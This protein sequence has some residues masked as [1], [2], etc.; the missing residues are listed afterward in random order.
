MMP[1][2]TRKSKPSAGYTLVGT[3]SLP[4]NQVTATG[5]AK[6]DGGESRYR[7]LAVCAHPVQYSSPYFRRLAQHP[8]I[9]LLVAYCSLKG[10]EPT[11]DPDFDATVKWDVPLL[12]GYEWVHVANL[13]P[14]DESFFG[15][16]NPGLWKLVRDGHFDAV[17]CSTGYIRASFWIARTSAWLSGVPFIFGTDAH[18]LDAQNGSRWR[19]ALKKALWPYLYRLATQVIV[20]SSGGRDLMLSLGI[21]EERI[22]FTPFSVDNR[23]W[24]EESTKVDREAVRRR[25]GVPGGAC[26]ILY[27]AKLQNWKRPKDLLQAFARVQPADAFL[28]IA[29]E[30]PLRAEMEKEAAKLGILERTRF[31][32]FV[33]QS[34]LPSVYRA[35][36]VFVLPSGYEPFGVVVNEAS[37]CGC[38]VVASDRVGSAK[39]LVLPVDKE[40]VYPCGDIDALAGVLGQLVKDRGRCWELGL[41]AR[42][43]MAS[44]SPEHTVEGTVQAVELAVKRRRAGV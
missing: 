14:D 42:T 13:G 39:D 5:S 40:L 22:S 3:E 26:V 23:W 31:L 28:V 30:G 44:W 10:A 16:N 33:N 20:P 7:V 27:C 32:G 41:A 2:R 38:A 37:L 35:A 11:H 9:E 43:R 8:R 21:P 36:D 34:E 25:W 15:L 18:S 6:V 24:L 12:D 29:G 1:Q 4:A 19:R 17:L